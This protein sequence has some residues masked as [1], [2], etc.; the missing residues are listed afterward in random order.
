[1]LQRDSGGYD[2]IERRLVQRLVFDYPLI[3]LAV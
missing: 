2:R 1:M 3:A